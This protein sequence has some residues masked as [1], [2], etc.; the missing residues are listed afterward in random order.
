M[1][2]CA[3]RS[4]LADSH[5]LA[6]SAGVRK[7]L[8]IAGVVL[9]LVLI[10]LGVW[11]GWRT[12]EPSYK[13]KRMSFWI[14]GV[15]CTSNETQEAMDQLGTNCIPALMQM[16]QVEDSITT[17][18]FFTIIRFCHLP[19]N[20]RTEGVAHAVAFRGF[21]LLGPQAEPAVAPLIQMYDEKDPDRQF[22]V[23]RALGSIGPAAKAGLPMLLHAMN[24]TNLSVRG[25]AALA[26]VSIGNEPDLVVPAMI[27][28][29]SSPDIYLRETAIYC[30]GEYGTN[31]SAAAPALIDLYH[32][33]QDPG[34][35]GE[36]TSQPLD[37]IQEA[38]LKIDP[39]AANKAGI[40]TN[41]SEEEIAKRLIYYPGMRL[42]R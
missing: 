7:R 26:I 33:E 42:P 24:S 30:L 29:L 17:R 19:I 1:R 12:N 11:N 38:L 20:I 5:R 2:G 22:T 23:V 37:R 34:R 18:K 41:S 13:G 3:A 15:G 14:R 39:V 9:V 21:H 25:N 28:D 16:V 32:R 10:G 40:G 6:H 4:S 31:A 8:S 35:Y 27:K 36:A